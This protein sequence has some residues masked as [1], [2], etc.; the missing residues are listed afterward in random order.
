VCENI[1]ATDVFPIVS[2][3]LLKGL[4]SWPKCSIRLCWGAKMTSPRRLHKRAEA[5]PHIESHARGRD[6]L[7]LSNHCLPSK[8]DT[9]TRPY[10]QHSLGH[11]KSL[12]ASKSRFACITVATLASCGNLGDRFQQFYKHKKPSVATVPEP[13]WVRPVRTSQDVVD[14]VSKH[15]G[16]QHLE[17]VLNFSMHFSA[18]KDYF[19]TLAIHSLQCLIVTTPCLTW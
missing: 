9:R 11:A 16:R 6:H 15:C 12:L 5:L 4:F 8:T 14:F 3:L 2:T 19:P 7:C 10:S 18:C 17:I 1:A 13:F